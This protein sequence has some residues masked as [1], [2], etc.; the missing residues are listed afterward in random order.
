MNGVNWMTELNRAVRHAG[1]ALL[2]V[3]SGCVVDPG[4][5]VDDDEP[6]RVVL[7]F[8]ANVGDRP[9]E[10]GTMYDA[11][12]TT[13]EPAEILD[14]RFYVCNIRLVDD[15][16]D[17]VPLTLEQDGKWQVQDVA[18]LDFENGTG[19]CGDTGTI[20]VNAQVVG[21]VPPDAY[22]GVM[23]DVGVPFDLNHADLAASPSPLN[24]G[25]MFW[26]WAIGHKF[27]RVDLQTA[28]GLR[29]NMHLGSTMCES[30]GPMDPPVSACARVNLPS[31]AIG[32]F[33]FDHDAIVFDVAALFA[34]SDLTQDTPDTASGCQTFPDDVNECTD[35]FPNLGLDFATGACVEGC[36]NQRVFKIGAP[37]EINEDVLAAIDRGR[38]AF[39]ASRTSAGGAMLACVNC[40]GDDGSGLIGPDIRSSTEAHVLEHGRGDG[41]HPDGVKFAD[42]TDADAADIAVYLASICQTDP[43]CD[44]GSVDEHGH[45]E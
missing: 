7:K 15:E 8:A 23:F 36:A 32:E 6:R 4:M 43:E 29:W 21:T 11:L 26:T 5:N 17:E 25:A 2:L 19:A 12:G 13:G 20:D 16:G 27:I 3:L 42:L 31:L 1:M 38:T 14:L 30:D 37:R 9:A 40:H 34:S 44:P 18:L 45:D 24:V 41:P 33:D 28:D 35:L 10:C 22:T 39:A